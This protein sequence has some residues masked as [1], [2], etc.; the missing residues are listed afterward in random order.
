MTKWL[1]GIAPD[2]ISPVLVNSDQVI[3]VQQVSGGFDAV[4]ATGV[5]VR[6]LTVENTDLA[7]L[8]RLLNDVD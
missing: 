7:E 8:Q 4:L 1:R 5:A 2:Q 6:L 3:V